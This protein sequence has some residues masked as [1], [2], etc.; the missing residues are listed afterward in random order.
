MVARDLN[1]HVVGR[2]WSREINDEVVV[3]RL[4]MRF[5]SD[6]AQAM[7]VCP[8]NLFVGC[9]AADQLASRQLQP[10]GGHTLQQR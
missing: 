5:P 6:E 1:P 7:D 10:R 3:F 2:R 8:S 9:T 4:N